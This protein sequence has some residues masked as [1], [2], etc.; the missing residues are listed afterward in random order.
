MSTVYDLY[1]GFC[2]SKRVE[3]Y[4]YRSFI[5]K[6]RDFLKI[7]RRSLGARVPDV[8]RQ[9]TGFALKG[10]RVSYQRLLVLENLF[11]NQEWKKD[12]EG[13]ECEGTTWRTDYPSEL[14]LVDVD[15]KLDREYISICIENIF[16]G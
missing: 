5:K 1:V 10:F 3:A 8:V 4:D 13:E 14:T 9:S 12:E 6:V 2:V 11:Q 15:S 16:E 7:R